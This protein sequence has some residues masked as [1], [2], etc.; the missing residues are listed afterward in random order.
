MGIS[1]Q[2]NENHREL[3]NRV[4]EEYAHMLEGWSENRDTIEQKAEQLL[5]CRLFKTVI[6]EEMQECSTDNQALLYYKEPLYAF[7]EFYIQSNSNLAHGLMVAM[8][9]FIV[10]ARMIL[11]QK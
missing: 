8:D 6:V 11:T 1:M 9:A 7:Y 4:E 3:V 5:I 2:A 10:Q